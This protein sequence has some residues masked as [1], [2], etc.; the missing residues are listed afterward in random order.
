M[1]QVDPSWRREEIRRKNRRIRSR[2]TQ[3]FMMGAPPHSYTARGRTHQGDSP[4]DQVSDQALSPPVSN[5][6]SPVSQS[7]FSQSPVNQSPGSLSLVIQSPVN[8][9]LVNQ[10]PV[11]GQPVTSQLGTGHPGTSQQPFTLDLL[12]SIT[13]QYISNQ[14]PVIV[15]QYAYVQ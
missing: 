6:Q 4:G 8:Q 12:S 11:T 15:P 2:L 10:S 3:D 5:H 14:S 1:L 7:L 13:G 9:S